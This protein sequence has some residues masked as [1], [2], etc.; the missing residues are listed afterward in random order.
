MTSELDDYEEGTPIV[1]GEQLLELR[2]MDFLAV[3][4][5]KNR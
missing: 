1:R 2:L 3:G 4:K 5:Y